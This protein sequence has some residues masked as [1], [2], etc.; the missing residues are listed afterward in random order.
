MFVS[1][2]WYIFLIHGLTATVSWNFCDYIECVKFSKKIKN[3][4]MYQLIACYQL[5]A[6][7]VISCNNSFYQLIT[8][9]I[10]ADN[11]LLSDDNNMLLAD[12]TI[13]T[14]DYNMLPRCYQLITW[15]I[16]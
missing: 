6:S 10:S 4:K 2:F 11:T 14:T 7:C 1:I 3:D 16:S 13:L 9:M 5:L 15:F 12:N 8:T